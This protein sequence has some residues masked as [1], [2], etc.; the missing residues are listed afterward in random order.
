MTSQIKLRVQSQRGM[1]LIELMVSLL[2]GM[3]VVLAAMGSLM[4][5]N[6]S[7]RASTNSAA[8][9][10]T[11]TLAMMQISQQISQAGSIVANSNTGS[12]VGSSLPYI[13]FDTSALGGVNSASPMVSIYGV[14][15]GTNPDTL[16]FSYTAPNDMTNSIVNC[17][18]K[19]PE[20]I[21]GSSQQRVI[22]HFTIN[23]STNNLV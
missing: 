22:N 18:G 19:A 5:T 20:A 14:D 17:I 10:Q 21:T 3:L 16:V 13:T 2:I 9:E 6:T 12:V 15:G 11:A 23:S 1:T 7:S 4:M 8:L